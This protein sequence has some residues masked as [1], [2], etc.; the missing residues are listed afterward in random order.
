MEK[1]INEPKLDL[2]CGNNKKEGFVGIDISNT[3]SADYVVNLQKFPWPIESDSA[4]EIYC[5]HYIEHIPHTNVATDLQKIVNESNSFEEFKEKVNKEEFLYPMDGL[6][7]FFNE[8][9]RILKPDGK[10][11]IV[12]PYYSSIRAYGDPTH[13]R[14]IC[15]W[16][17]LYVDKEWRENNNLE[18]MGFECD[19]DAKISY[20]ISN[21]LTLKSEE[22]RQ[23][24]FK[25]DINSIED[26]IM[27]LT[28]KPKK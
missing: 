13:T 15:D 25:H 23:Q 12:S 5:G 6:I 9:Y 10:I 7:K 22:V 11:K 20:L 3:D 4:E 26:I 2:A 19:F 14:S 17:F 24:A 27:D 16:T 28:K 1:L 21:E 8:V 18:H